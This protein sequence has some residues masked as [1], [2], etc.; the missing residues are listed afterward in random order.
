MGFEQLIGQPQ[1]IELL[2]QA[3][4]KQRIAPA[5]LFVGLEGVGKKLAAQSF[6]GLLMNPHTLDNPDHHLEQR[7]HQGNHPDLFWVEPT[8]KHQGHLLTVSQAQDQGLKRKATPQI[9]IEQIRELSRFL[10]RPPLEAERAVVVIEDAHTMAEGAA[11]ALLKTLEEPGKA[12]LIL[13]APSVDSLLSTLVSRCQKI[14]FGALS[15][16]NLALVLQRSGQTQILENPPLL[17]IAQ[18][19]PGRALFAWE[20]LQTIPPEIITQLQ[21]LPTQAPAIMDLALAITENLDTAT[22]LWLLDY[23]QY[24]HWEHHHQGDR[25][26]LFE[27]AKYQLQAYVQPLLVWECCLL[28]VAGILNI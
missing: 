9:R 14:P 4:R 25:M 23:W 16:E 20:Q 13:M 27:Q 28:R 22:Q 8:Y 11:N 26:A 10:G 1:A 3:I 7:L 18:G 6:L 15:P 19:S 5:Y 2:E 17:A 24:L 21:T 12:T